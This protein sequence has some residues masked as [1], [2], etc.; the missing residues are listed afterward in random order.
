MNPRPG[1]ARARLDTARAFV[2]SQRYNHA[3]RREERSTIGEDT[4]GSHT[5]PKDERDRDGAVALAAACGGLL[6][7]R[8]ARLA[9]A[10]SCTGGLLGHLLTEVPGSSAWF[11]G[12]V[13]AYDDRI[14]MALLG[15]PEALLREYGAVSA[16]CAAAM[17]EGARR[18]TGA[19]A[20]LAITGIAGPGGGTPAKPVGTVYLALAT[21]AGTETAHRVWAGDRS[22][23]KVQSAR[24]ALALLAEHLERG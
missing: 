5:D 18:A 10:E 2:L 12:G 23:N 9:V 14:K 15:V 24:A 16:P 13:I 3:P 22:A 20:A 8:G 6:L 4:R 17:A 19:D 21:P 7:A 1:G 11:L